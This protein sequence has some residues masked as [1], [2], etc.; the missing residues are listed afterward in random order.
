MDNEFG[1]KDLYNVVLKATYP[2]EISGKT[3]D[4][5]ETIAAFDKITLANFQEIKSVVSAKG[6]YSNSSLIIWE[7]TKEV[8]LNF[9]QGVFSKSQLALLMNSNL[10]ENKPMTVRINQRE[11]LESDENGVITTSRAPND[12]F[13]VYRL[14]NGEKLTPTKLTDTT[15]DVG[16]PYLEVMTDYCYIYTE[17]ASTMI[18]G[19]R[20]CENVLLLSGR[21]RVKDSVTGHITTGIL[22]IPKLRLMSS[23][24]M[25]L[26]DDAS[27][28]VGRFEA[29][30]LPV[31][32]RGNSKVMEMT[33]L[34]DDIDSDM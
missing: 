19:Q 8:Q 22:T 26:G 23:M 1:F 31:G 17:A 3:I 21:T 29:I 24:S 4:A 14:D 5:G 15:F 16:A 20:L 27:P 7:N 25:R 11:V 28:L 13:F 6:G 32:A 34:S 2:I 9:T 30:A 33:Y 18:I 10:V 12:T